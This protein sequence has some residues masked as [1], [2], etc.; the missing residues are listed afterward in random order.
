MDSRENKRIKYLVKQMKIPHEIQALSSADYAL[1]QMKPYKNLVGVERKT[2][3][4]L[5]QSISTQRL[6]GQMDKVVSNYNI[7][8]LMISGSLNDARATLR[9][10]GFRINESV[11]HGTIASLTV[12]QGIQVLWVPDDRTLIDVAHRICTKVSEGKYNIPPRRG[13]KRSKLKPELFLEQFPGITLPIAKKM[14]AR[15]GSLR[16]IANAKANQLT[17]VPNVGD[18]KA[19]L[20]E[21]FFG[22]EYT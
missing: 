6:F 2:I 11:I 15:F 13:S 16:N 10:M 20:I 9:K 18:S 7:P 22:R 3:H 19:R 5:I 4:D 17:I 21:D 1:R 14:L 8:Y 12:R